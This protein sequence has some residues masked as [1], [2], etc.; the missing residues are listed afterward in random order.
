MNYIEERLFKITENYPEG[1]EYYLHWEIAKRYMSSALQTIS[2]CFPH[3]S[4]HDETHSEAI[5]NNVIRIV[6]KEVIDKMSVVDLWLLLTSAYYHDFGMVITKEDKMK[7]VCPDSDFVNYLVR[8]QNDKVSP[9]NEYAC[10]FEIKDKQIYYK[11]FP[12]I[13]QNIDALRFLIADYYRGSHAERS[14]V[15]IESSPSMSV[16]GISIPKRIILL[17]E[18]ICI[19]HQKRQEEVLKMLPIKSSGC[20]TEDC[21]PLY[22]AC[23]LRLGDLLDIDSNRISD[24]LLCTLPDVPADSVSYLATNKDIS[25]IRVDRL[26]IEM[27]ASCHDY[28]VAKLVNN[29]FM[30]IESEVSFQT[31]NWYKIV[32]D[33]SYG[34]LPSTG[35]LIVE[36]KGYDNFSL[37]DKP[38]FSIDTDRAIEM[39][40]GAGLYREPYQCFR[41]LL[42]N[43]VDATYLR[44]FKENPSISTIEEFQKCCREKRYSIDIKLDKK[45]VENGYVF[46]EFILTDHGI[47]MSKDEIQYLSHTGSSQNNEVKQKIIE[48]MPTW[49]RPSG[50]FGIGF[51]SVF[52][53]T[54]KV[55]MTT[56]RMGSENTLNLILYNPIGKEKGLILVKTTKEEDN[57]I[58]TTIKFEINIPIQDTQHF[59]APIVSFPGYDF[60]REDSC[61]WTVTKIIDEI[62]QF[63]QYSY[64]SINLCFKDEFISL[65]NPN[66]EKFEFYDEETGLQVNLDGSGL[67]FRNQPVKYFNYHLPF[68]D[69]GIN[70]LSGDAKEILT[71]N[72]NGV[73]SED[74]FKLWDKI[75]VSTYKYII[76][77]YTKGDGKSSN[78][79]KNFASAYIVWMKQ[80]I[81]ETTITLPK[82]CDEWKNLLYVE[83]SEPHRTYFKIQDLLKCD[84]LHLY[85]RDNTACFY[86]KD[87]EYAYAIITGGGWL[88]PTDKF[89]FLCNQLSI[90]FK[91]Y[92]FT[93]D[94]ILIQ[95]APTSEFI[96]EDDQARR[97]WL[98]LYRKNELD[99]IKNDTNDTGYYNILKLCH[100]S[101][102]DSMLLRDYMPCNDRYKNLAITNGWNEPTFRMFNINYPVM[103][104]PFIRKNNRI[105]YLVD[106]KVVD[107]VYK[108]RIDK[109]VSKEQIIST[110]QVFHEDFKNAEMAVIDDCN[111]EEK[112]GGTR[113]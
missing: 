75:F 25:Y 7:L 94:G 54:D 93:K 50:S 104:C 62:K 29:W 24:V 109:N 35:Q 67:F 81:N 111:Y 97:M 71:L 105:E 43:A 15:K 40:Q 103:L 58:G 76:E 66:Y 90:T 21:H 59:H 108:H 42:Q 39:L 68:F 27:T 113:Y 73:K 74:V 44:V 10:L 41:E 107:F 65:V 32:P 98:H 6:G 30:M 53:I 4:L 9:M 102:F 5:L 26:V 23:L 92:Q 100:T 12:L 57:P 80:Y 33:E 106:E 48:T 91:G 28:H 101:L 88:N 19:A 89:L 99:R 49:M 56:R 38:E 61:E 82:R 72:R 64:Q 85:S 31:K 1:K 86:K 36:L 22:I 16:P 69:F 8:K 60:A 78:Y 52:L 17:L 45:K 110:F 83:D 87:K 13:I 79:H 96:Q 95:K 37:K 77:L 11:D 84:Y 34:A 2:Q 20:G 47:G 18:K 70:I 3:Y 46:W 55:D 112:Y 51:Q 63:S 14:A